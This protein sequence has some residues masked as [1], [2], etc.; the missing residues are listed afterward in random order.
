VKNPKYKGSSYNLLIEWDGKEPTWEPLNLIAADDKVTCALYSK[1]NNM[2]DKK[3][4]KYLKKV[5]KN[6]HKV[7]THVQETMK[8]KQ[9][10]KY[11]YSIRLPD[12]HKSFSECDSENGNTGWDEANQLEI[13]L[14]DA[15][16]AFDDRGEFT[17]DKAK[18][19]RDKGYQYIKM[20]MI[21]DT[22]HDGRLQARWVAGGHMTHADG[23]DSYSSVVSLRTL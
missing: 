22:K 21:Y 2:L 6:V 5:A 13:K 17:E 10:P 16:K 15:F 18:A 19:L 3:G 7:Y 11:K 12:R 8:L 4:W 14:L 23:A 1:A 20:T 9:E